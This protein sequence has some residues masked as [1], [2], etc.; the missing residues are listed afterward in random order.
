MRTNEPK[1]TCCPYCGSKRVRKLE[2]INSRIKVSK[3]TCK[4]C[5]IEYMIMPE[6]CYLHDAEKNIYKKL[7]S[8]RQKGS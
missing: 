4:K 1:E 7:P 2:A 5:G 6:R 3:A 8:P